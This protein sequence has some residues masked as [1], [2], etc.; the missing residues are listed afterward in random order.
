MGEKAVKRGGFGDD[1][2]TPFLVK[3]ALHS[4]RGTRIGKIFGSQTDW[5]QVAATPACAGVRAIAVE[6]DGRTGFTWVRKQVTNKETGRRLS[7][8]VDAHWCDPLV[9]VK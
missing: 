7:I 5:R 2:T 3:W 6:V 8:D 9:D 1:F 4:E